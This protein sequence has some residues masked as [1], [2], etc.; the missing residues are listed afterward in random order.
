LARNEASGSG[1][2]SRPRA[3]DMSAGMAGIA[4]I[5][6]GASCACTAPSR[7]RPKKVSQISMPACARISAPAATTA[8][9]S[10]ALPRGGTLGCV[11]EASS[12]SLARKPNMGGRP[13]IESAA[14]IP[15]QQVKGMAA[16][17]PPNLRRSRVP[18]S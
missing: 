15:T 1:S 17:N 7:G 8:A 5:H 4:I 9:E 10:S 6:R 2:G 11:T 12:V 13:A 16:R 14:T 3:A 18:A